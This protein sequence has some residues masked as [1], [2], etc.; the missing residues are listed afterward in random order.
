MDTRKQ[1]LVNSIISFLQGELSGN[2]LNEEKKESLEVAVQCLETAFEVENQNNSEKVDLLSLI[3]VKPKVEVT[4]EQKA[5]AEEYK[6][7]GN[8]FMKTSEYKEAIDEYTKYKFHDFSF[9][10][11]IFKFIFLGL[12]NL[13]LTMLCITATELLHIQD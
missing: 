5:E 2:I 4:E 7:K 6:T 13:I 9:I 11:F 8:N 10:S 12:L 3:T 1:I